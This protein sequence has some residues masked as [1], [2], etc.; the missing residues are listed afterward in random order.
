M[1]VKWALEMR[2]WKITNSFLM[3]SFFVV[4]F[5]RDM[6]S[7]KT[8]YVIAITYTE[9]VSRRFKEHHAN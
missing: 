4:G 9:M 6:R 8:V 5:K 7:T 2:L 3:Y 1:T